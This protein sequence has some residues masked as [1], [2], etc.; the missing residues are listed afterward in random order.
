MSVRTLRGGI[1]ISAMRSIIARAE[2]SWPASAQSRSKA[3]KNSSSAISPR[4]SRDHAPS[5]AVSITT[6]LTKPAGIPCSR[7]KAAMA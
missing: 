5:G 1:A 6:R 2:S 7:S 4:S 3:T